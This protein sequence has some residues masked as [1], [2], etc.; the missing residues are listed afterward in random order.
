[1]ALAVLSGNLNIPENS[2]YSQDMHEL[3]EYMLR[4]DPMERPFIYSVIEKT[5]DLI[6]KLK[7]D[8]RV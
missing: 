2:I 3:I 7:M 8:D 5:N 6:H 1:M 4:M